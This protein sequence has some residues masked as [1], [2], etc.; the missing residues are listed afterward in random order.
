M[1]VIPRFKFPEEL[2]QF[3]AKLGFKVKDDIASKV[4]EKFDGVMYRRVWIEIYLAEKTYTVVFS[5]VTRDESEVKE[6]LEMAN[7]LLEDFA[8]AKG[9]KRVV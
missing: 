9:F 2:K 7:N 3:F 4:F 8:R 5:L 1:T 6:F